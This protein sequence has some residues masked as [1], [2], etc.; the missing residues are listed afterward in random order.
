[1][2]FVP[3]LLYSN[4]QIVRTSNPDD[5]LH[6]LKWKLSAFQLANSASP[7]YVEKGQHALSTLMQ[8]EWD[9]G[10]EFIL[11]TSLLLRGKAY[12]FTVPRRSVPQTTDAS[13]LGPHLPSIVGT[14]GLWLGPRLGLWRHFRY[15]LVLCLFDSI[16][17]FITGPGILQKERFLLFVNTTSIPC[18]LHTL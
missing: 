13:Q 9:H 7:R 4:S 11:C 5:S 12:T 1:M 2:S 6:P 15:S 3:I 18:I 17:Q 14:D 10:S 16:A 8:S